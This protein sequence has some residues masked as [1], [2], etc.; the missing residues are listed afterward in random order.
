M[1]RVADYFA[2]FLADRG[3]GAA[4]MVSGGQMMHLID[5]IGRVPSVRYYCNH[6]EQAS[7]M[8]ADGYARLS[9]RAGL[10]FATGGPGGTNVVTGLVGAYQDSVPV[11]FL[12]GQ[13]KV[14]DTVRGRGFAGLRQMG[15]LEVDIVPIVES[16]TKYA[17]F[18]DKPADARFHMEKAYH[19]ATTGRPGPVLLDVPLDVQGAMIDPE[20][21]RGYDPPPEPDVPLPAAE[22]WRKLSTADRPLLLAGRGVRSGGAADAFRALAERLGVPVVTTA[23]AKDL[24]PYDHPLFVGHPGIRGDRAANFAV[25]TADVIVSLGCSLHIQN[26]GWESE[27]FAPS[28]RAVIH[29]DP[30]EAVLRKAE[31]ITTERVHADVCPFIA[32]LA[33]VAA[34]NPA[35]QAAH[36][37]WRRRCAGW[38]ERYASAREPHD[39]GP[40]DG[41]ANLYEVVDVL[42]DRLP[43]D[44]VL[45]TDAGQPTYIV[46]QAFRLRGGQR[47]L[48][49]A[50][51]AEMGWALPAALGAAAAD[52][53]RVVVAIVGD[54]SIQTNLQE[55]QTLRHLGFNVKV[56]VI[57]NDGYASIRSTQERF[58]GGFFVG[59]TGDSGTSFPDLGRIAA[60]YDLPY[61]WCPHRGRL[62]AALAEAFGTA[63]PVVCGIAGQ[64][65]QVVLPGVAS[66]RLPDGRFRSAPLHLMSPPVTEDE[67]RAALAGTPIADDPQ[68]T[69]LV[70]PPVKPEARP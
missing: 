30:D 44:A 55:L 8:A 29:V 67:L 63:G 2:R 6:H 61:V 23:F 64:R 11:V 26:I 58:F 31:P 37:D 48:A 17:A 54:G 27:L 20:S 52:P 68:L 70:P 46:P 10:C 34:A 28:A 13:C 19:L 12:T 57:C 50:S 25:Q 66:V 39:L 22:V 4:F 38:K 56:L 15:F 47:Y 62:R 69:R 60:A 45:L 43:D 24:L 9:G 1:I 16:A 33:R 14:A 7:A 41:P 36:A 35:P 59:S 53:S 5:A 3:V 18:V 42:S 40:P 49:P 32:A 51:M 65:D 21:L